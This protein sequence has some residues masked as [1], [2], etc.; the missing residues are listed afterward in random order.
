MAY[1]RVAYFSKMFQAVPALAP[2]QREAGG[3]FVVG[4]KATQR[5]IDNVYPDLDCERYI[6]WAGSFNKGRRE[7]EKADIIVTGSP[8]RSFLQP[9]SAKKYMVFHGTYM[10][11]SRDSADR[12]KHFDH[13]FLTGPRMSQMFARSGI[14][15]KASVTGY[16]PFVDFPD[17]LNERA[18]I[19]AKLGLDPSRKTV[20]YTPSRSKI[21]SWLECAEEIAT[22]IPSHFNLIMRPHPS[23]ALN[24]SK[25]DRQSYQN[26]QAIL[27]KS[28]NAVLDL[29][30]CSLSEVLCV[31]DLVVSDANS[32][33]EESLFYDVPQ[34]FVETKRFSREHLRQMGLDQGMHVDDL[35]QLLT[36][37][38]CGPSVGEGA[39][40]LSSVEKAIETQV[41]YSKQREGYFEWVFGR[42]DRDSAKRVARYLAC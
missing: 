9:Y 8:Y 22:S 10:M 32:P 23:Q 38:D 7:L 19:L 36:L 40:W 4:R 34:L 37:Y 2:I 41:S 17:K 3:K 20:V 42:R 35:E 28:D 27:S 11:M 26:V 13:L 15:V 18:S 5:A 12:L 21:G 16:L 29:I 31:A 30:A 39:N 25:L 6:K 1:S 24:A 33:S 14:E